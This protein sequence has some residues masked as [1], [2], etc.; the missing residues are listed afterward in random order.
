M[1][2]YLHEIDRIIE[3]LREAGEIFKAREKTFYLLNRR[4]TTWRKWC[5]LQV[6][7]VKPDQLDEP[8]GA[9]KADETSL[10]RDQGI[11]SYNL[12]SIEGK[13][14]TSRAGGKSNRRPEQARRER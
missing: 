8:L 7:I 5:D 1:A 6:T 4:P 13:M 14:D 10:N 2:K 12:L 3:G 9:I 11:G